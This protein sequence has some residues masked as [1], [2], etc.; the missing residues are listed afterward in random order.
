MLNKGC[1]WC[2]L[3]YLWHP[4][5]GHRDAKPRRGTPQRSKTSLATWAW[6]PVPIFDDLVLDEDV[7][8][9]FVCGRQ[10]IL[11]LPFPLCPT[12]S[13]TLV[14]DMGNLA[15]RSLRCL[16]EPF[17]S[18]AVLSLFGV[19]DIEAGG[20][21]HWRCTSVVLCG[22]MAPSANVRVFLRNVIS[23]CYTSKEHRPHSNA[24]V[25]RQLPDDNK[26]RTN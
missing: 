15:P 9:S 3:T 8:K 13:A 26:S 17:C 11:H 24:V 1:P 21:L 20:S 22:Q 14:P 2:G 5:C 4:F 16:I 7:D 19:D 6:G 25:V 10:Q 18:H 23:I 12:A